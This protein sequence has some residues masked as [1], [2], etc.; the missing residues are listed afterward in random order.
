MV[1]QEWRQFGATKTRMALEKRC[2]DKGLANYGATLYLALQ[3]WLSAVRA[4][5]VSERALL[6]F[7]DFIRSRGYPVASR[8][9]LSEN[10]IDLIH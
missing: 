10:Q 2:A 5:G 6:R 1:T 4:L 7:A 8:E 3:S 9:I